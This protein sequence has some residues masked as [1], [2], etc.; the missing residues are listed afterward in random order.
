VKAEL[1]IDAS[2]LR[3]NRLTD[4]E[5]EHELQHVASHSGESVEQF[6]LV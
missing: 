5:V 3:K 2:P 6:A 1:I 4:E